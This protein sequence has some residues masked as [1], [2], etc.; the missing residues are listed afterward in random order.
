[1]PPPFEY[2]NPTLQFERFLVAARDHSGLAT[3]NMA[4]NMVVGVLHAFR[5]RLTLA[6][7]IRFAQALPPVVR[8]LFVEDWDP[9]LAPREF[10]SEQDW[11]ADVRAVRHQHNFSPD[12]AVVAVARALREQVQ[13]SAWERAMHDLPAA[14]RRY[15]DC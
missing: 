9:A 13:P 2:Q 1:M 10:G 7:G 3:T 8:A 4:W 5:A 11:L 6:E 14:F 12:N 15:W